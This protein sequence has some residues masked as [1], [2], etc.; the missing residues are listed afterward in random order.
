MYLGNVFFKGGQRKKV[1]SFYDECIR[2]QTRHWDCKK[3]IQIFWEAQ[4][5][6]RKTEVQKIQSGGNEEFPGQAKEYFQ[7][8]LIPKL[9]Q[10]HCFQKEVQAGVALSAVGIFTKGWMEPSRVLRMKG[11]KDQW[12]I[13]SRLEITF[14]ELMINLDAFLNTK[15][16]SHCKKVVKERSY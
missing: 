15:S 12:K 2:H 10:F 11:T 8:E 3:N 13:R 14:D 5:L 9:E 4:N 16:C 7:K 1:Y 6:L